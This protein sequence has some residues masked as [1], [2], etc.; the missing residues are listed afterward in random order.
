MEV[1]GIIEHQ[2]AIFK[3]ISAVL[4]LGNIDFKQNEDDEASLKDDSS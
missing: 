4:N 2:E 3:T 1:I